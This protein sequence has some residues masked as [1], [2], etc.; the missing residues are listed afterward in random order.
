MEDLLQHLEKQIK[1]LMDQYHQ[2][3][4]SNQQL[5]QGKALLTREKELLLSKQKKAIS[6]IETL[7]TRLKAIEK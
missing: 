7:V 5:Y 4:R 3:E 6:Q 1:K 2:I